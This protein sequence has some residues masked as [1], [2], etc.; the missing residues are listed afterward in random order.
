MDVPDDSDISDFEGTDGDDA[1]D[2]FE[3]SSDSDD[4]DNS[5]RAIEH[6]DYSLDQSSN[7]EGEARQ[8]E[9]TTST[10]GRT[11]GRSRG[12]PRGGRVHGT[13]TRRVRSRSPVN[14]GS[15]EVSTV[16]WGNLD[17]DIVVLFP[18]FR[19]QHGPVNLQ[20]TESEPY[21]FFSL[22]FPEELWNV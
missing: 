11:S 4:S 1:S 14:W 3:P 18:D 22:L 7:S 21:D 17:E 13:T 10:R 20:V 16:R 8:N 5:E 15:A 2:M 19:G 9:T 12:R 6:K